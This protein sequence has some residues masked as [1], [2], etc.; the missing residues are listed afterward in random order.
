MLDVEIVTDAA[1]AEELAPAWDAL[2]V[3]CRRPYCAPAW[4]LA[5]WRYH[6]SEERALRIVAVFEGG[7]L[8]GVGPFF[9]DTTERGATRWRLLC[10]QTSSRIEPV[11]R[12][13]H[14]HAVG[15]AMAVAIAGADPRPDLVTFEGTVDTSLWP[16]MLSAQWPSRMR[17]LRQ[18]EMSMV[19][20]TLTFG[21]R[22]YHDWFSTR[23][24]NFR[25]I[26]RRGKRLVEKGGFFRLARTEDEARAGVAAF[27][28]LHHAR[29]KS[30]GGS[31]V[32]DD[33]VERMVADAAA[34]MVADLR[35]RL[36]T[37]EMEGETIAAE[38]FLAAGGEVSNWLGGFDQRWSRYGPSLLLIVMEIEQSWELGDLRFDL[39]SGPQDYKERFANSIDTVEWSVVVPPLARPLARPALIPW[40]AGRHSF[41][42]L[43]PGAKQRLRN[44]L[45]RKN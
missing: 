34:A 26:K 30:R 24:P 22:T 15:A 27:A 32:L 42:R 38:L 31:G 10:S 13:G 37:I 33:R 1:R 3:A 5:W 43:S 9:V 25:E 16:D 14:E 39:G 19:A 23:S 12:P 8:V 35:L 20:P 7:E 11:A 2:A 45:S 44:A 36:W 17:P 29:W 6:S 4:M 21:D 40:Y 18:V 28:R 41:G